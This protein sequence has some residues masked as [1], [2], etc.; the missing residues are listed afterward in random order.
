MAAALRAD[1]VASDADWEMLEFADRPAAEGG[2]LESAD[3]L[4]KAIS[5][6]LESSV[7]PAINA[8]SGTSEMPELASTSASAQGAATPSER[9]VFPVNFFDQLF[10]GGWQVAFEL[11][12]E[13]RNASQALLRLRFARLLLH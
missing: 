7:A 2:R 9:Q 8:A 1:D 4:E 12:A 6:T 13:L 10:T 11:A 5:S 3:A